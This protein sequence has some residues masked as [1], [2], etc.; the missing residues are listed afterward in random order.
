MALHRESAG[1]SDSQGRLKMGGG[2]TM[3]PV[4]AV[5]LEVFKIRTLGLK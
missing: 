3:S 2:S 5:A 1:L 4:E